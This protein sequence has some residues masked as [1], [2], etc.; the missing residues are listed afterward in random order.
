MNA[1]TLLA[2][3]LAAGTHNMNVAVSTED[4]AARANAE[5]TR[6]ALASLLGSA[7][8]HANVAKLTEI[9]WNVVDADPVRHITESVCGFVD[10]ARTS[11]DIVRPQLMEAAYVL[12]AHSFAELVLR[13]TPGKGGAE[14]GS[15][16]AGPSPSRPFAAARWLLNSFRADFEALHADE[17]ALLSMLTDPGTQ[18]FAGVVV[19][20]A[21]TLNTVGTDAAVV[22][23]REMRKARIDAVLVAAR[24]GPKGVAAQPVKPASAGA[25][26]AAAL[27]VGLAGA[28]Q[29]PLSSGT[30]ELLARLFDPTQRFK[31]ILSGLALQL[32]LDYLSRSRAAFLLSTLNRR[33]AVVVVE[34][35]LG[36]P[37][38]VATDAMSL[39]AAAAAAATAGS[40][41]GGSV[42]DVVSG[43]ARSTDRAG[44]LLPAAAVAVSSRR[45][46]DARTAAA[47]GAG[48]VVDIHTAA[49]RL[50]AW[51]VP[52]A[53]PACYAGGTARKDTPFLRYSSHALARALLSAARDGSH[54]LP[55]I[56]A[57]AIPAPSH[58]L[59]TVS[60]AL[61][62][63]A[64][65]ALSAVAV[66]AATSLVSTEIPPA[67]STSS[68]SSSSS[69]GAS[70]PGAAAAAY[71][72]SGIA[73][74]HLD[75]VLKVWLTV[76]VNVAA[77]M[78]GSSS[79]SSGSSISDQRIHVNVCLSNDPAAHASPA[80]TSVA[81]SPCLH[82]ALSGHVD[83]TIRL[84]HMGKH[85]RSA[86]PPLVADLR[87]AGFEFAD[88]PAPAAA[89]SG[90]GAAAATASASAAASAAVSVSAPLTSSALEVLTP[91]CTYAAHSGLPVWSVAFS[92]LAA[93]VFVSGGRDGTACLWSTAST[94]PQRVFAGHG[95]DV[96]AVCLHPNGGYALT[97]SSDRTVRVWDTLEGDCVRACVGHQQ[98]VSCLAVSPSGRYAASGDDSGV[99]AVWDLPT[100]AAAAMLRG[101]SQGTSVHAVAFSPDGRTLASA[102]P[103]ATTAAEGGGTTNAAA[104]SSS[105]ACR[106]CV[107][108]VEAAVTELSAP[109]LAGKK[110]K[111]SS[112]DVSAHMLSA[113]A[114]PHRAG[115]TGSVVPVV[116]IL[117]LPRVNPHALLLEA[118]RSG[119]SG[120]G[121][122]AAAVELRLML[123]GARTA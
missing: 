123:A 96:T 32:L 68:S 118:R 98:R 12:L 111:H 120:S 69:T 83:G 91:L 19:P 70:G 36:S 113:L 21:A 38:S 93:S 75:G 18:L 101:H 78:G 49:S 53:H 47:S 29:G 108:D 107:F 85:L 35:R 13:D 105:S 51:G 30:L 45:D 55:P 5:A 56:D 43:I 7:I 6:A 40:L 26:V 20:A 89:A 74:G 72:A 122:G 8:P 106:I 42:A 52:H 63:D 31:V 44:E 99:V 94:T 11:L 90:A 104:T 9:A 80:I 61:V 116:G 112:E 25:L 4:L 121:S 2:Q 100:G 59:P 58:A 95:G 88:K 57:A 81:L 24:G 16:A 60:T 39:G 3:S 102:G 115:A 54:V 1:A 27:H 119:A 86:L 33:V 48:A 71:V 103:A 10:W 84:W 109:S 37:G 15:R 62:A 73:A 64:G 22:Q 28:A 67:I 50:V 23:A 46:R 65:D 79:S 110:R 77:V 92:Q 97:A 14:A 17:L 82:Y 76:V 41:T 66:G 114:G 87:S 34:P 117:Q